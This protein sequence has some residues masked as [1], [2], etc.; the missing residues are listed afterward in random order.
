ML[1][2]YHFY[3]KGLDSLLD[4]PETRSRSDRQYIRFAISGLTELQQTMD[5]LL[6]S[7]QRIERAL[8]E[9]HGTPGV[10]YFGQQALASSN[11]S[12]WLA[13]RGY[14]NLFSA[15]ARIYF[16]GCNVADSKKGVKFLLNF[17]RIFLKQ[18]G[19]VCS[20]WDSKGLNF[21]WFNSGS[22]MHLWGMHIEAIIPPGGGEATVILDVSGG[23]PVPESKLDDVF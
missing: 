21:G 19:G 3:D 23:R 20:G 9:T 5:Q 6:L 7:G 8:I 2:T 12:A 11:L 13:N 10:V 15:D 18:N 14:E 16:D 1:T 22:T 17:G 4:S